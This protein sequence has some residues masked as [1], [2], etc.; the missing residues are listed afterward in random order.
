MAEDVTSSARR[1]LVAVP[2]D[3]DEPQSNV[4]SN[5]FVNRVAR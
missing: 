1:V 5:L 3:H 4:I 2:M